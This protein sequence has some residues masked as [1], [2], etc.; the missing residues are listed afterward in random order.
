M[1][2]VLGTNLEEPRVYREAKAEGEQIG[3]LKGKLAS[4]PLLLKAGLTVE[5]IAEQLDL[6]LA[7]VQKAAQQ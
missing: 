1:E 4:V 2:A 5:Q 7:V 6:E 3:E